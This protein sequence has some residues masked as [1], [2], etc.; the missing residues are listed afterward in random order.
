MVTTTN[1]NPQGEMTL[2]DYF[3]ESSS[4]HYDKSRVVKLIPGKGESVE[5][6]VFTDSCDQFKEPGSESH[7]RWKIDRERQMELI[8]QI[9]ERVG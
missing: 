8:Q 2:V 1:P 6:D 7:T 3:H 5:M 9:G 4:G